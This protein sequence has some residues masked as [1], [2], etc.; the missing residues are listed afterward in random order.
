M[1]SKHVTKEI[2]DS[3]LMTKLRTMSVPLVVA[4][5][6]AAFEIG[7]NLTCIADYAIA[8]KKAFFQHSYAQQQSMPVGGSTWLLPRKIGTRRAIEMSLLGEPLEA[9]KTLTWGLVDEVVEDEE[10]LST[11]M[12]KAKEYAANPESWP[13]PRNQPL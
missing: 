11:A 4:V 8:G 3:A 6:G 1:D 10:L 9:E 5:N 12:T 13:F 2:C 7:V